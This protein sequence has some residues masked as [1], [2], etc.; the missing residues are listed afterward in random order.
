[1][2]LQTA[3]IFTQK[4]TNCSLTNR[5]KIMKKNILTI[6][7]GLFFGIML[8]VPLPNLILYVL[9]GIDV[10]ALI[11]CAFIAFVEKLKDKY[12]KLIPAFVMFW[13]FFNIGIV[14]SLSRNIL[15]TESFEKQN[16]L[17]TA[18]FGNNISTSHNIISLIIFVCLTIVGII[19]ANKGEL[20]L[21]DKWEK[22]K[23]DGN[24]EE[25]EIYGNLDKSLKIAKGCFVSIFLM[26]AVL[27]F[28]G[29]LAGSLKFGRPMIDCLK[30]SALL[31]M[32]T[33]IIFQ[34][35][36]NFCIF[37]VSNWYL[38]DETFA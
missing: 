30:E 17:S 12:F 37:I 35:L 2:I 1:M 32:G 13:S 27:F 16:K 6:I 15:I 19:L 33:S 20:V 28:G 18:L 23:N 34:A 10:V 21:K 29:T 38:R 7:I 14:V 24:K 11:V 4:T 3:D 9:F 22:V 26:T 5:G 8:L 31:A 36:S 25:I